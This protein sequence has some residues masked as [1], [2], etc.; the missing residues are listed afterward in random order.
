MKKLILTLAMM[1]VSS[2]FLFSQTISYAYD[3][4]GNRIERSIVFNSAP[5]ANGSNTSNN[6]E[7]STASPK[8]MDPVLGFTLNIYPNPTSG[9]LSLEVENLPDSVHSSMQIFDITGK[10]VVS[11]QLSSSISNFDISTLPIGTYFMK[12]L[13]GNEKREWK[14]IKI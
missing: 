12:V 14:I 10:Q 13:V 6:E 1:L 3:N 9:I 2:T 4:S 7:D 5:I 11:S 8:F